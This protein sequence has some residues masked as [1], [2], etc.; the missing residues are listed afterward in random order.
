MRAIAASEIYN[1]RNVNTASDA[2]VICHQ[3]QTFGTRTLS[4]NCLLGIGSLSS[5]LAR[6]TQP[7]IRL[8]FAAS[9]NIIPH[10]IARRTCSSSPFVILS[11]RDL[12][13][14]GFRRV[15]WATQINGRYATA[16]ALKEIR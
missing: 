13:G 3:G 4:I 11:S 15:V 6:S 16:L 2:N 8:I 5:I 9:V 12:T 7:K 14:N 10:E 1:N